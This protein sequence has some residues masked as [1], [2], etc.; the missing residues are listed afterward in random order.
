MS[1]SES[2]AVMVFF[3]AGCGATVGL[4]AGGTG[5][6][7]LA[8]LV[9]AALLLC[10]GT[11]LLGLF[12]LAG[13]VMPEVGLDDVLDDVG[14]LTGED[15]TLTGADDTLTGATTAGMELLAVALISVG[16][17][18]VLVFLAAGAGALVLAAEIVAGLGCFG[19]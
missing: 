8:L 4:G 14:V 10:I 3:G 7:V 16:G 12:G 1:S 9:V 13:L 18:S 11:E 5:F 19:G 17:C 15:D 2:S 6:A